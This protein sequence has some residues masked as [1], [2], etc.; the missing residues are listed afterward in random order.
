MKLPC[1]RTA[2]HS[3]Y[4]AIGR[5]YQFLFVKSQYINKPIKH[6][7][8]KKTNIAPNADDYKF[9]IPFYINNFQHDNRI[10][11][12]V[13]FLNARLHI[14]SNLQT[15]DDLVPWVEEYNPILNMFIL[16]KY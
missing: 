9:F 10:K 8:Y 3:N 4:L 11:E 7:L 12:N 6:L 14:P 1:G 15:S 5:K 13:K 16:M 2:Q